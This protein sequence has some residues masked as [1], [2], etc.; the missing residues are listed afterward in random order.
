MVHTTYTKQVRN[1]LEKTV[2]TPAEIVKIMSYSSEIFTLTSLNLDPVAPLLKSLYKN[3]SGGRPC[4]DPVCML[5]SFLLMTLSNT[6]SIT[7]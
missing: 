5:R 7:D 6:A 4:R 1:Y 3:K 2:K